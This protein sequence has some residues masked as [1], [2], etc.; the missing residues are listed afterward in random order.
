MAGLAIVS[1]FE[2]MGEKA[3]LFRPY[4]LRVKFRRWGFVIDSKAVQQ[5]DFP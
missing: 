3:S 1:S 2:Q 4:R 5:R